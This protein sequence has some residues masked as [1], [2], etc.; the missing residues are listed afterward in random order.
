MTKE[1]SLLGCSITGIMNNPEILLDKDILQNGAKICVDTNKEWAEKIGINQATRVTCIKPDGMSA[2]LLAEEKDIPASGIHPH[3]AKKYFRRIQVNKADPVYKY[4]KKHNPH[5]CEESVWSAN[6]TDDVITFPIEL[7]GQNIITKDKLTAIQH[8]KYAK[9]VQ[10][11]WVLPGTTER[12]EKPVTHN[13]SITVE[14]EENEWDE[15]I[16]YLFK[17]KSYFAA[18]S[19]ISKITGYKQLP[20]ERI[21]TEEKEEMLKF[22]K[23]NYKVVNY[24]EFIEDEDNTDMRKE[25]SCAG[26]KC[27]I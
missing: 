22:Y 15:V 7:N 20:Y 23:D 17:N 25:V 10:R 19:F 24:E 13:V 4:F 1:E 5:M 26:G 9:F 16:D 12:N 6:N 18:V 21:D 8:L 14:V 27:E 2:N 3:H 11:N